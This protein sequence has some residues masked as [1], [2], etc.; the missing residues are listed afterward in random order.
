MLFL[1][2]TVALVLIAAVILLAA[3]AWQYLAGG[4]L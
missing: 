4:I 2:E 1:R 3:A